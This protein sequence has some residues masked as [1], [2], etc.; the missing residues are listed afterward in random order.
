MCPRKKEGN[1]PLWLQFHRFQGRAGAFSPKL[2]KKILAYPHV[3]RVKCGYFGFPH[4]DWLGLILDFALLG[5][6][7]SGL[8]QQGIN[9]TSAACRRDRSR[10][11][12][13][14]GLHR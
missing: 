1:D 14:L 10:R 3:I 4:L 8:F 7:G 13:L 12:L 11:R 9:R 2:P 6:K 5:S